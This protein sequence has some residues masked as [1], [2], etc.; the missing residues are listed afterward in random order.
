MTGGSKSDS[1][2]SGT[3][4]ERLIVE[5]GR[6]ST[7]NFFMSE[8]PNVISSFDVYCGDWVAAV[9]RLDEPEVD[10]LDSEDDDAC[11]G[12]V[13]LG[14][15]CNMCICGADVDLLSWRNCG[16]LWK[17]YG[18]IGAAVPRYPDPPL[19]APYIWLRG[20]CEDRAGW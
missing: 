15:F 3:D 12:C 14:A 2:R 18:A 19:W 8:E 7:V 5:P 16:V 9:E 4:D 1:E 10:A 13:T 6:L 11:V 20:I 17:A